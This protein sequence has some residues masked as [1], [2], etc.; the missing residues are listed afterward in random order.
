MLT[1]EQR[2]T[3]ADTN[4]SRYTEWLHRVYDSPYSPQ[5][6]LEFALVS[7]HTPMSAAIAGWQ[8]TRNVWTIAELT[9]RLSANSVLAPRKKARWILELRTL[10]PDIQPDYKDYRREHKLPGLGYCKI[11]FAACLIDPL[12]SNVLC[13]DTH[14]LWAVGCDKPASAQRHLASYEAIESTLCAEAEKLDMPPFAY[15]WAV[16]DLT[17]AVRQGNRPESHSFLWDTNDTAF[18]LPL[19]SSLL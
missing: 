12:G 5:D 7:A 6:K 3:W 14:M 1:R 10:R 2:Q 9:V 8:A 18:K 15:Q 11:S 4:R 19:F 17:R 16:W 13:L